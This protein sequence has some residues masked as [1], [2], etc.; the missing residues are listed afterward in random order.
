[1]GYMAH[2]CLLRSTR[3]KSRFAQR[4]PSAIST[5]IVDTCF[6]HKMSASI[7]CLSPELITMIADCLGSDDLF[8]FRLCSQYFTNSSLR[9]FTNRFFR[10]RIHLLTQHSLLALLDISRHQVFGASIHTV[11]ITPDHLAPSGP[12]SPPS[13]NWDPDCQDGT[14]K[15]IRS[16]WTN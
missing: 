11:T 1:M 13:W 9:L 2:G 4:P 10:E 7:Y 14:R 16:T 12:R 8:N 3:Q 15:V 6:G 5:L